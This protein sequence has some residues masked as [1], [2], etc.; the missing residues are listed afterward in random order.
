MCPVKL[1]ELSFAYLLDF[2]HISE[3]EITGC[4]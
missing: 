2:M 1:N 4:P 3:V